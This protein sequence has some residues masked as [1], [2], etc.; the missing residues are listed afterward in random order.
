M[1][2]LI[3]SL[4]GMVVLFSVWSMPMLA[5]DRFVN[6]STQGNDFAGANDCRH[7][8]MPCRTL[9]HAIQMAKPGDTIRASGTFDAK[10]EIPLDQKES[11]LII[12][13]KPLK[14]EGQ[15]AEIDVDG[16]RATAGKPVAIVHITKDASGSVFSGFKITGS[17]T[18]EAKTPDSPVHVVGILV[19]AHRVT[20]Q[21]NT[22]DFTTRAIG[23]TKLS[24]TSILLRNARQS[25]VGS[26][27]CDAITCEDNKIKMDVSAV[28]EESIGIK[29]E[30]AGE[31]NSTIGYNTL[32]IT[33]MKPSAT[34]VRGIV[35]TKSDKNWILGNSM[36]DSVFDDGILI[37]EANGNKIES[38]LICLKRRDS[39]DPQRC[40]PVKDPPGPGNGIHIRLHTEST[41]Q[42]YELLRNAVSGYTAGI[43][44]DGTL[45]KDKDVE[46]GKD[47]IGS[48]SNIILEGNITNGNK[49]GIH[50]KG[51]TLKDARISEN[52]SSSNSE[53]GISFNLVAEGPNNLLLGNEVQDNKGD[54]IS[55]VILNKQMA[56]SAG[57][58]LWIIANKAVGN[59]KVGIRLKNSFRSLIE[60]NLAIG[61]PVDV[62]VPQTEVG[63]ALE[64]AT[65]N[66]V[67]RNEARLNRCGILVQGGNKNEPSD[68]TTAENIIGIC[69]QNTSSNILI[70]N[71]I[72]D[73][74]CHGI[75]LSGDSHL[76]RFNTI[77]GN[78]AKCSDKADDPEQQFRA[79]LVLLDH[80]NSRITNNIIQGNENGISVR[81]NSPDNAFVCNGISE[82]KN[83]GILVISKDD[84]A[85]GN[86]FFKNNIEK[87]SQ[88]GLRNFMNTEIVVA[89]N[90]W[91]G[92]PD[93][94]TIPGGPEKGD[95]ILGPIEFA[96]WLERP[97][98]P[99]TCSADGSP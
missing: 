90:N 93:G 7:D 80:K 64:N 68:N 78:A 84:Q 83:N 96:P 87:N 58:L 22:L 65:A 4:C 86:R 14:I 88:F 81:G 30:G 54:G 18:V 12:V 31:G 76:I 29:F 99:Q 94:P 11:F 63:I 62:D 13:G 19:D 42:S 9:T 23:R 75:K 49:I 25:T 56:P 27:R 47:L 95:K 10:T 98:D 8:Q 20:I 3:L 77:K 1:R 97:I 36:E 33:G 32:A 17:L 91:W 45:E 35:L 38:N 37:S 89:T 71:H 26:T 40:A 43:C 24:V 69:L 85:I 74:Q 53:H 28:T 59:G 60:A 51:K 44:L 39:D 6:G 46:C 79:G 82:N 57:R 66:K 52:I 67:I 48:F 21:K 34:K 15:S 61:K 41:L 92:H 5:E 73:N 50:L 2:L 70:S 55:Y 72:L 16:W